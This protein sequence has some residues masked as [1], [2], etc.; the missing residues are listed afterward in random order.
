MTSQYFSFF[1]KLAVI[2]LISMFIIG[3]SYSHAEPYFSMEIYVIDVRINDYKP[4]MLYI[5]HDEWD[6]L[7]EDKGRICIGSWL[8]CAIYGEKPKIYITHN[9][10]CMLWHEVQHQMGMM[11]GDP[12]MITSCTI[13]T[14][15]VD[16][17]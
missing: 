13:L 6:A 1:F 5:I 14:N 10:G 16:L 2:L 17:F 3:M 9:N 12:R 11:H 15:G 8:G 4:V 7:E